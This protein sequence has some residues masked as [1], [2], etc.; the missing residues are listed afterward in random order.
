MTS[1]LVVCDDPCTLVQHDAPHRVPFLAEFAYGETKGCFELPSATKAPTK[2]L[3]IPDILPLA[4]SEVP[5]NE[6]A[7][8]DSAPLVHPDVA[9]TKRYVM[10]TRMQMRKTGTSH[11]LPECSYHDLS[12]AKQG[13]HVS[14]MSQEGL[15]MTR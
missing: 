9:G 8:D 4:Y 2:N 3:D 7:M 1:F 13:V 10:G 6:D 11:K 14:T 15:Q 12:C 5:T